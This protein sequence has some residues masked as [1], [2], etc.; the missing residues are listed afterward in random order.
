[1]NDKK[2]YECSLLLAILLA[3]TLLFS[4]LFTYL[5]I[6][7]P[8]PPPSPVSIQLPRE[9]TKLQLAILS[10]FIAAISIILGDVFKKHGVATALN[11]INMVMTV[12]GVIGV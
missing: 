11:I 1:M 9:L 10:L 5:G 6:M 2:L 3:T 12:I 4:Q 8:V 7:V